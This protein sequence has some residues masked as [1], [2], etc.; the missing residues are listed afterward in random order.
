MGLADHLGPR[1]CVVFLTGAGISVASGIRP[2]RGPGGLW[3]EVDPSEWANAAA[4][5]RDPGRCWRA[6]HEMASI[7][8]AAA[9]NAAHRAIAELAGRV[10]SVVVITQ[11]IDGL[12]TRA[13]AKGVL[14]IHGS[15][16]HLRC[17][18]CAH[19]APAEGAPAEIPSCPRCQAPLRYDLV[20]FDEMLPVDTERAA[21]DA[22]RACTCFVAVGTSGVVWPAAG[23]AREADFAGAYTAFVN[24]EPLDPPNPYFHE[25]I[26]GRAEQVLP[27]LLGRR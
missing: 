18:A 22:L 4:M 25:T 6:H 24:L 12:H 17:T 23:Y 8:G 13:G 11:N 27:T 2:F 19:R 1:A 3:E 26:L 10:A 14:E 16:S 21:R 15:L 9:P 7:V 5:E 20:L